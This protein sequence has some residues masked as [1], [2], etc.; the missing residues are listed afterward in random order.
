MKFDRKRF[1]KNLNKAK[2]CH[3]CKYLHIGQNVDHN[4]CD[5]KY[6]D[7]HWQDDRVN[8]HYNHSG[9]IYYEARCWEKEEKAG[10]VK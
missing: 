4:H 7:G 8:G 6:G 9:N 1:M 3:G 2:Q 10:V 5:C